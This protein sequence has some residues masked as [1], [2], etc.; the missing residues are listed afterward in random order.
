MLKS[1]ITTKSFDTKSLPESLSLS[2]SLPSYPSVLLCFLSFQLSVPLLHLVLN[3][4]HARNTV[5]VSIRRIDPRKYVVIRYVLRL[6]L[7]F[8]NTI[9]AMSF[10]PNSRRLS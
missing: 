4:S 7:L 6:S 3:G 8:Q 9:F 10:L 2:N 1:L 5:E